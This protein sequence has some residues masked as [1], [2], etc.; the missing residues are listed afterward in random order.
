MRLGNAITKTTAGVPPATCGAAFPGST[1]KSTVASVAARVPRMERERWLQIKRLVNACLDIQPD[2]RESYISRT[3]YGDPALATEVRSL[4]SSHEALGD[5]LATSV[6][7][8][9][10][11]ELL[12]GCR[13]GCYEIRE[14]IAEGGTQTARRC[15]H[16]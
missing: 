8:D 13:V 1:A 3:C 15:N 16:R 2:R 6:L 9:A 4:L 14:P 10:D 7:D 12:S 11:E 5:F